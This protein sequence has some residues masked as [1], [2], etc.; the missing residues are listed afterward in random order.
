MKC[1]QEATRMLVNSSLLSRPSIELSIN[2]SKIR[3]VAM[4]RSALLL[5]LKISCKTLRIHT[6]IGCMHGYKCWLTINS[7]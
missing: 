3:L 2:Y 5:I 7:N 6:K 1:L 4:V